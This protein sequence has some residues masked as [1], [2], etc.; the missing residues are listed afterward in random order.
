LNT[1]VCKSCGSKN[2]I[3]EG[4]LPKK[5]VETIGEVSTISF[6]IPD[7][8]DSIMIRGKIYGNKNNKQK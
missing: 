3:Y 1:K 6:V 7:N 5:R 2:I 4:V 8:F